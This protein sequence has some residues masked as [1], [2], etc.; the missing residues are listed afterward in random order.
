MVFG[1]SVATI[2]DAGRRALLGWFDSVLRDDATRTMTVVVEE[3]DH[4]PEDAAVIVA[5]LEREHLPILEDA[6]IVRYDADQGV[7]TKGPNFSDIEPLLDTE[8]STPRSQIERL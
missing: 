8:E 6:D 2:V 1:R 5:E 3:E 4:A 7:V